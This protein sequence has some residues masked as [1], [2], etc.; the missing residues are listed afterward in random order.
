MKKILLILLIFVSLDSFCQI[1]ARNDWPRSIQKEFEL[2]KEQKIDTFL[3]YYSY[4]GTWTN[5]PD[6]CNG[7]T[8]VW[9]LWIKNGDCY[10]NQLL[11]DSTNKKTI[12]ISSRP[13][14]FFISHIKDYRLKQNYIAKHKFL[15]PVP[16]DG[17]W[18]YL[19]FM[20]SESKIIL[21]LSE[22]QRTDEIWNKFGWIKPTIESIDTTKYEVYRKNV[23]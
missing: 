16:T 23:R 21:N 19:I 10:A 6:S 17:S 2:I 8:S 11:C 14:N 1:E 4:L 22:H 7:I 5:L 15:P 20:T 12:A 9:I 13:F 3:V 18:E